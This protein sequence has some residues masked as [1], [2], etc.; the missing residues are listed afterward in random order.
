MPP[1]ER[2]T[3]HSTHLAN[4]PSNTQDRARP[5]HGETNKVEVEEEGKPT[6]ERRKSTAKK[7]RSQRVNKMEEEGTRIQNKLKG[8]PRPPCNVRP[9][10]QKKGKAHHGSVIEGQRGPEQKKTEK[11]KRRYSN[12]AQN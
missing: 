10:A 9:K 7:K 1:K 2:V 4:R 8:D 11:K 3:E 12:W 6:I 5:R